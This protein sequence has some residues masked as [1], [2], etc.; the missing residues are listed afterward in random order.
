L[1][2]SCAKTSGW[3]VGGLIW[4]IRAIPEATGPLYIRNR[5]VLGE[6]CPGVQRLERVS[7]RLLIFA[8]I[9]LSCRL[10]KSSSADND[11]PAP[12]YP[13]YGLA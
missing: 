12:S 3:H 6:G 9:F 7:G 8:V 13:Q 5:A 4:H 1:G 2:G 11:P 10:A